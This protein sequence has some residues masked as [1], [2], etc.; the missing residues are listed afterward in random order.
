[1]DSFNDN[2]RVR[3]LIKNGFR[4][5][6]T[7]FGC[8][9]PKDEDWV[10]TNKLWS[11]IIGYDLGTFYYDG[12]D[13]AQPDFRSFKIKF[14]NKIYNFIVVDYNNYRIWRLA[15]YLMKKIPAAYIEDKNNRIKLF[16]VFKDLAEKSLK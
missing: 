14:N 3:T 4:T 8:K 5:G 16:E 11:D 2:E 10:V 13:Y 7:E 1:M 6:S 12:K 9:N 15:T